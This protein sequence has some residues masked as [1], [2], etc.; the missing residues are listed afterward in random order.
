MSGGGILNAASVRSVVT[1]VSVLQDSH[2][3]RITSDM[4]CCAGPH[5]ISTPWKYIS[6]SVGVDMPGV[7][8]ILDNQDDEGNGEVRSLHIHV[9]VHLSREYNLLG[10]C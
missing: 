3:W 8:T 6:T 1:S 10:F 5:T 9:G 7:S 2:D 4:L